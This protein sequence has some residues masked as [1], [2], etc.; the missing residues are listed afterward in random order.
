[1]KYLKKFNENINTEW[2]ELTITD[3]ELDDMMRI[4][5]S[6]FNICKNLDQ[7]GQIIKSTLN[8]LTFQLL[9]EDWNVE[10]MKDYNI[11]ITFITS[12]LTKEDVERMFN[13][14]KIQPGAD[15]EDE[16]AVPLRI[17]NR[18]VLFLCS[19]ERGST[20]RI[21]SELV[22]GKFTIKEEE[23]FE[24]IKIFCQIINQRY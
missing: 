3:D 19:P 17:K 14:W 4:T 2:E 7:L 6:I 5:T 23:V 20:I 1:M 21:E 24:I 11:A 18:K 12:V 22:N 8:R 13:N 16:W 15:G 10:K 9:F